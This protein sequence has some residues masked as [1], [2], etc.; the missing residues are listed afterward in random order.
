MDG[1]IYHITADIDRVETT[2]TVAG[3][4]ISVRAALLL[5]VGVL[6]SIGLVSLLLPALGTAALAVPLGFTPLYLTAVVAFVRAPDGRHWEAHLLDRYRFAR[7]VKRAANLPEGV[8]LERSGKIINLRQE[9]IPVV[10]TTLD[11][12]PVRRTLNDIDLP[13]T[14]EAEGAGLRVTIDDKVLVIVHDMSRNRIRVTVR[15]RDPEER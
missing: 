1:K 13:V 2:V 12:E 6:A 11:S 5:A 15:R 10:D 7:M 3:R 14:I 4:R 8:R 9:V